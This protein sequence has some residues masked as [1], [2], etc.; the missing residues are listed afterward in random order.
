MKI[1]EIRALRGPNYWSVTRHRLIAML[2]DLEAMENFP[3][4]RISGFAQRIEELIPSLVEHKC[5]KGYRGGF[6]ERVRTGTWMGHVIEHIAIELQVLAGMDVRFGKTRGT[7]RSGVYNV[8]FAYE[9]EEAGRYAA[10]AAFRIALALI[11]GTPY[12]IS[13]D[14]NKLR[15]IHAR[16][17]LGPSTRCIVEEATR[18]NIPVI[19]LNDSSLLQL[20]YGKYQQRIEATTTT[21]TSSIAVGIACDKEATKAVLRAACVPVP[22]GITL[23][24]AEEVDSAVERLG[25][26]LVMKP[27]DGNHGR[28]AT[29]DIINSAAAHAAF[30][31]AQDE[32]KS[33]LVICERSITGKDYRLLVING[34][35]TAAALRTPPTLTGNGVSTIRELVDFANKDPRRGEGHEKPMTKIFIDKTTE[36]ILANNGFTMDSVLPTGHKL[37]LKHTANISSGGTARDV[38]DTVHPTNIFIAERI[39]RIVGLDICGIDIISPDIALPLQENGGAVIEVNAGPGLRMHIAPGEGCPR[40][41]AP[42]I[43]DMLF[44]ENTLS[45]IPIVA[46]TG[47][48]GKTTTTRLMAHIARTAGMY[49]GCTTTDGIYIDGHLVQKGDCTGPISSQCIL[50]DPSVDFAVLE[51]ARGGLLRSGLA[52]D[53]CDVGIV[54]NVASDH[55]GMANVETLEDMARVKSV[56]PETVA[57]HGTA[58]LNADDDLVYDMRKKSDGRVALFSLDAANERII[59]HCNSG[60]L[61]AVVEDN[62]IV[63]RDGS[64]KVRIE[65]V[66]NIPLTFG[67]RAPFM[68]QNALAAVLAAYAQ[69][70]SVQDIRAALRSFEASPELTPGRMNTIRFSNF[71]VIVDYA[72]NPAGFRAMGEFLARTPASKKVGIITGVGDRRDEDIQEL[73]ALAANMFDEIIIRLDRDLRGRQGDEMVALLMKGIVSAQPRKNIAVIPRMDDAVRS[74]ISTATQDSLIVVCCEGVQDTLALV[75]KCQQE[76]ATLRKPSVTEILY[77]KGVGSTNYDPAMQRSSYQNG[78]AHSLG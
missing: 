41:V 24:S 50:R 30:A 23:G 57:K 59:Q 11:D 3:T 54:T 7:G 67:G 45:R 14:I 55:L 49:V 65:S 70:I 27:L 31:L 63:V 36:E 37:A 44:P 73:G 22:E 19:R 18:R 17:K 47:T 25:F 33:G 64:W 42:P 53:Y 5:S 6:L 78:Y 43:V 2:L 9:E 76:E 21:R 10:E 15:S 68:V 29:I 1:L 8:V 35:F 72:H 28:G 12:D 16:R 38:T 4:D 52:F 32:S 58:V 40:N 66:Q 74:A 26:P 69:R 51:C 20:G 71:D 75:Q 46:I 77:N 61:A 48:N 62:C 56:I 13:K 60:G 39:A 34:K